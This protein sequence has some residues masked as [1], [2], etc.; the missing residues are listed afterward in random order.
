MDVKCTVMKVVGEEQF[1]TMHTVFIE[2]TDDMH[3]FCNFY[4]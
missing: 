1:V 4:F 2:L 3:L